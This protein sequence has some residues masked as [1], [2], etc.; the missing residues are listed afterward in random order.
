MIT[1][2]VHLQKLGIVGAVHVLEGGMTEEVVE[3]PLLLAAGVADGVAKTAQVG[4]RHKREDR[5]G[6]VVLVANHTIGHV[7]R[8]YDSSC[9]SYSA[10]RGIAGSP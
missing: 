9:N 4:F 2:S 10:R 8:R 7:V 1:P 3:S 6:A 5:V